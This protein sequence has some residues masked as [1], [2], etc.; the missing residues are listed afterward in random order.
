MN[1]IIL[2]WNPGISSYTVRRLREDLANGTYVSNWSVWEHDKAHKGDRFFMVRCG[3]GKTGICMSGRFRSEP[4]L[5]ED[6]SGKGRKVYYIDLL[7]DVVID[8]DAC[9][10][11][12]TAELQS[13]IPD[14]KWDGGHSGRL[15]P[16]K[17]ALILEEKWIDFLDEHNEI[18]IHHTYKNDDIDDYFEETEEQEYERIEPASISLDPNST[19]II[20]DYTEEVEVA[21][22]DL[23]KLKAE[24]EEK[25]HAKGLEPP[26]SYEF[27]DISEEDQQLF[28][29]MVLM[30][31]DAY[32]GMSYND[33]E[34]YWT[35]VTKQEC[36]SGSK[37]MVMLLSGI[38]KHPDYTTERLIQLGVPKMI[39]ESIDAMTQRDGEALEKYI[40]R[41][42]HNPPARDILDDELYD[43]LTGIVNL[44]TLTTEDVERIN[45]LLQI[46]QRINKAREESSISVFHGK[47]SDFKRWTELYDTQHIAIEGRY[48]TKGIS[49]LA[50]VL[51]DTWYQ[52]VDISRMTV[53]YAG[54][55][56]EYL[57]D[58]IFRLTEKD[59]EL[60]VLEKM[61][62]NQKYS[63]VFVKKWNQVVTE[64]GKVL[65][66]VPT[67][68]EPRFENGIEIVGCAA[69]SNNKKLQAL[70]YPNGLAAIG[71]Y[72]FINC[73][74]LVS[75]RLPDTVTRIGKGCFHSC[76]IGDLVLSKS[77]TE[78]PYSAFFYNDIEHLVIPSS[79]KR[80]GSEAFQ[81][82]HI[83]DDDL[84]IPEG[85]EVIEY[86][87]FSN[88]FKHVYLPSTLKE[89]AYDFYYEEM[90]DDPEEMKPYV[91]IHPDNPVYYSEVGILYRR[92]TGKEAL[93]KAGREQYLSEQNRNL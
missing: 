3:E 11:L 42:L 76:C 20:T 81:I 64:D 45:C 22:D 89:I 56:E 69:V 30:A 43:E 92:D 63:S 17:D 88:P 60:N 12:S 59:E 80:I 62:L 71:D 48:T 57:D 79:V 6:W 67:D 54:D 40:A 77:L 35:H 66:H 32:K 70:I 44:P 26:T 83:G 41:L 65:V 58:L 8:P 49:K 78:I 18:F 47:L 38:L 5:D 31:H 21:G 91:E 85:V 36:Y 73:E 9:P 25:I 34:S 29:R 2:F 28:A 4:Y 84:T 33:R 61:V 51:E 68:C 37:K 74:N 52:S 1:T 50:K 75:V 19:Y 72:A 53:K 23:E 55:F 90:V 14:F 13:L 86:N 24:L 7:A 93:G 39:V 10:I 15:L 82:C 16:E 46:R 87:A 27:E